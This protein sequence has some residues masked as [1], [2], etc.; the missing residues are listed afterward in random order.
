MSNDSPEEGSDNPI[1]CELIDTSAW[2]LGLR[3]GHPKISDLID[4]LIANNKA[5][6]CRPVIL[7][8]LTGTKTEDQFRALQE[9]LDSIETLTLTEGDW[10]KVYELGFKLKREGLTVPSMDL[11]IVGL[12]LQ[13]DCGL[14]HADRHF[15]LIAELSVGPDADR[16]QNVLI[17][18][19]D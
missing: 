5:R 6:I 17:E 15:D 10:K 4:S 16:V 14:I 12:A 8:L 9:D 13:S 19:G 3:E 7:E 18:N 11:I 2:I 1:K